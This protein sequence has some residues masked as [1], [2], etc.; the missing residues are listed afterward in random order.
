VDP[1]QFRFPF[2]TQYL[3]PRLAVQAFTIPKD[4]AV[5]ETD[6]STIDKPRIVGHYTKGWQEYN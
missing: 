6:I 2:E 1:A 5:E 3:T 4:L